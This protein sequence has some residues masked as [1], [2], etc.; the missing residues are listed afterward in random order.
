MRATGPLQLPRTGRAAHN[1]RSNGTKTTSAC[2]PVCELASRLRASR[3]LMH[4]RRLQW[5]SIQPRSSQRPSRTLSS[6][7]QPRR[8]TSRTSLRI[9]RPCKATW[10]SSKPS[11]EPS[12]TNCKRTLPSRHP[13]TSSVRPPNK[14]VRSSSSV[15]R[16]ENTRTGCHRFSRHNPAT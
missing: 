5:P 15:P 14:R 16:F 4:W 6:T 1:G 13:R 10:I 12:C 3:P 8:K 2:C 9:S 11:F 7:T